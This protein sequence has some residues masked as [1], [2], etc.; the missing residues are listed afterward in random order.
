MLTLL[1]RCARPRMLMA[2]CST[3]GGAHS[4]LGDTLPDHVRVGRGCGGGRGDTL[5]DHVRVG[6]GCGGR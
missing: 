5:P 3:L 2:W 1:L 6:R 4:Q